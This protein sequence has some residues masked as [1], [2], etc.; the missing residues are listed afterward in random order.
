MKI[1]GWDQALSRGCVENLVMAYFSSHWQSLT[2]GD[3]GSKLLC[4]VPHKELSFTLIGLSLYFLTTK[5]DIVPY[6]ELER[7]SRI[8][9]FKERN[10][11]VF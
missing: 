10:R 9:F 11:T 2:P 1:I 5:L 4:G 3:K 7:K 6:K 8:F